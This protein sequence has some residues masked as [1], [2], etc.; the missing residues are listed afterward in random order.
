M[1]MIDGEINAVATTRLF[2]M[3]SKD[4]R[5]QLTVYS[6]TVDSPSSNVMCLPVPN[7][8]S[9]VFETVYNDLFDDCKAS[10]LQAEGMSFTNYETFEE[11]DDDSHRYLKI[12]SHGSYEVVLVP[13][14]KDLDRIPPTFVTL[15]DQIK[16][17]LRANYSEGATVF[18]ILLCKLRPGAVSY[19][20]FAYS[21]ALQASGNLFI[22]TR[23]Y[24]IEK[25]SA[26][27]LFSLSGGFVSPWLAEANKI[28][29]SRVHSL[30]DTRFAEDWDHDIYTVL[31]PHDV[32]HRSADTPRRTNSVDWRKMPADYR[33]TSE[34]PLRLF[35]RKGA[36]RNEDIQFPI[37]VRA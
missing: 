22:P 19:E 9:V 26:P 7:P 5:R 25:S 11:S 3:P 10:F 37:S 12:Q 33:L 32:A 28:M 34:Y 15:S 8:S 20:P 2:V 18:G 30:G 29:A 13:T 4:G 17:Y 31:T 14:L 6:N 24:H 16:T 36:H 23:H 27:E 35:T 21:H 1:C